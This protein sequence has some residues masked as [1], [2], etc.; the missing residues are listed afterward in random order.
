MVGLGRWVEQGCAE[1]IDSS[2]ACAEGQSADQLTV[3]R[4]CRLHGQEAN[5]GFPAL[6]HALFDEVAQALMEQLPTLLGELFRFA[7]R[8]ELVEHGVEPICH[9]THQADQ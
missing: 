6:I 9:G 2:W 4:A 1:S 7:A 8:E 3:Q 5:N